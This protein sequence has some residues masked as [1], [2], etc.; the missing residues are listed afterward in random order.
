MLEGERGGSVGMGLWL[1]MRESVS[2]TIHREFKKNSY[3][4]K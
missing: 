3:P 4:L 2:H 1:C